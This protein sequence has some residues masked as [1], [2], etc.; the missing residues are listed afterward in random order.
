MNSQIVNPSFWIV[1]TLNTK[2]FGCRRKRNER[3]WS[4]TRR[5]FMPIIKIS[6]NSYIFSP[7]FKRKL[8]LRCKQYINLVRHIGCIHYHIVAVLHYFYWPRKWISM[9]LITINYISLN[10]YGK[11]SFISRIS[12]IYYECFISSFESYSIGKSCSIRLSCC[13]SHWKSAVRWLREAW[14]RFIFL[15]ISNII[16]KERHAR[17][18][19]AVYNT[20]DC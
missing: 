12:S 16:L 3:I 4:K 1:I 9:Y 20:L 8:N 19:K 13:I 5:E 14:N 2:L 7:R 17:C 6:T 10:I 11:I 15:G 18:C